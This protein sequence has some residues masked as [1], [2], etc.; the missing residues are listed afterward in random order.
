MINMII[1]ISIVMNTNYI[2]INTV[3]D[4]GISIFT[5]IS[6]TKGEKGTGRPTD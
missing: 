2:S 6:L 1:N 5:N 4:A 3:I